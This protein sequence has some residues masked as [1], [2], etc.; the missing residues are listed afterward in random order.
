[1]NSV[2][3]RLQCYLSKGLWNATFLETYLTWFFEVCKFKNLFKLWGSSFFWKCSKL[4]VNSENTKRNVEK[5]FRFWKCCYKLS[6]LRRKYLLLAVNG[7][8]NFPNILRITQRDFFN[9]NFLHMDE[10]MWWRC[11]RSF[12]FAQCF[13]P[14]T[15]LL[16]QG[17]SET[18][19]FRYFSVLRK[20]K[21]AS[22]M[23]VFFF[24]KMF[25]FQS[26]FRKRKKNWENIFRFWDNCIRKCWNKLPLL[27]A[28][29]LL[30]AVN[31]LPKLLY[32]FQRDLFNRNSLTNKYGKGAVVQL[33]TVFRPVYHFTY[34]RV[35]RN[36]TLLT[37]I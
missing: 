4:S 13:G 26:K 17:S 14:F 7:S 35:F 21:N 10:S 5:N 29:Y 34:R 23:R 3:V 31:G 16:V 12:S 33:W 9:L 28:E 36:G 25:N 37:F 32:I 1:M 24:L 11:C 15:T 2:L 6:L 20:F 22:A 8:T 27:R 18:D 19:P 30:S